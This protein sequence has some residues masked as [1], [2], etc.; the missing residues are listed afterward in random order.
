MT[1]DEMQNEN[2]AE[3]NG[4]YEVCGYLYEQAAKCNIHLTGDKG[5]EGAYQ[6]EANERDV[7][8]FVA[9]LIE[10][11]YDEYGEVYL[12]SPEWEISKWK[13]INAYKQDMQ[14][15]SSVQIL[16]LV[17]SVGLVVGLVA[18]SVYLRQKLITR[19]VPW[20]FG[21]AGNKTVDAPINKANSGIMMQRSLSGLEPSASGSSYA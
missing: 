3:N 4:I 18:Y 7:C 9:S 13:S 1:D 19:R 15:V 20:K 6:Q 12:E 17:F 5:Y 21:F 11:N 16:G 14:A 10:N 2:E 8:N